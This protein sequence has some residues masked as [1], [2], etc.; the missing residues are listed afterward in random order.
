MA[1]SYVGAI[2][3]ERVK[4][5]QLMSTVSNTTITCL[6]ICKAQKYFAYLTTTKSIH[7]LLGI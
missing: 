5:H 4:S 7:T 2:I 3:K 1:V 6:L